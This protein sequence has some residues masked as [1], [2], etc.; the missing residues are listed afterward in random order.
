MTA[1]RAEPEPATH[2]QGGPPPGSF[3]SLVRLVGPLRSRSVVDSLVAV[4]GALAVGMI[5]LAIVDVNPLVGYSALLGG[6]FGS[7]GALAATV[8]QATPLLLVGLALCLSFESGFFNIGAGGQY[9]VGALAAALVGGFVHLPGIWQLAAM[10]AAAIVAGALWALGPALLRAFTGASE[11]ITTL[12]LSY[13]ASYLIDYVVTGPGR[14]GGVVN[15]TPSLS[16]NAIFPPLA[17]TTQLTA[18]VFVALA[19]VPLTW[20]LLRRTTFGYSL[21]M[22]GRN[23]DAAQAAG[24][25]VKRVAVLSLTVSGAVAGLSG[26]L[27]VAAVTHS[28]PQNFSTEVGFD[29]IAVALLAGNQ[30]FGILVASF[31]LGGLAAGATPMEA[32]VGVSGPFVIFLEAVIIATVVAMPLARRAARTARSRLSLRRQP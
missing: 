27:E 13:V 30:P 6:A 14:S 1:A 28:V 26:M 4:A 22:V 9:G 19:F 31:L 29:A 24:I 32:Q 25:S 10:A 12:M 11:I 8:V 20:F 18:A 7:G 21:R 5:A 3:A 17:A 16:G 15:Q 2:G 23:P